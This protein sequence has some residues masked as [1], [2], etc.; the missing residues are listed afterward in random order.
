MECMLCHNC[1][2]LHIPDFHS[3]IIRARGTEVVLTRVM[4][5]REARDPFGVSHQFPY[6]FKQ[7]QI[8]G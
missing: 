6:D 1:F 5:K 7:N 8:L 4:W 2:C 3:P